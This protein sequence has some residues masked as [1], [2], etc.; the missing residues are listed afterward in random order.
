MFIDDILVYLKNEGE[1]VDHL[2]VVLQVLKE[3]QL[4]SKY[5]KNEY[6]LRS[7]AF[8]DH[9]I[10]SKGVELDPRNTETVKNWPRPLAPTDIRSF[11]GIVGYYRRF[12]D[13]FEFIDY[14]LTTLTQKNVKFKWSE[15][16][17]RSFQM[18]KEWITSAPMLTLL[19]GTKGFVVYCDASRVGLGY[20]L[21][22][23]VKFIAYTSRQFNIH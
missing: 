10:S 22:Q 7:V 14:P 8:L 3:H 16:C 18:L 6:W 17:E 11:L 12:V 2:R 19:E 20:V 1:H 9:I 5:N 4:F 23:H 13:G 21:M 15:S